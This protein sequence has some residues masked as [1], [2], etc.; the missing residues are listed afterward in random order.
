MSVHEDGQELYF[1]YTLTFCKH[2]V[3]N[4]NRNLR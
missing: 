2:Y 1:P 3:L 4:E